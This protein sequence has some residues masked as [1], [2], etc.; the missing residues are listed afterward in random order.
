MRESQEDT[1]AFRT[2]F[3]LVELLVV[4]AIIGL[5]VALLLPAVQAAREAARRSQC[6]NNLRQLAIAAQN[7]HA[8]KG[9]FPS[10]LDQSFFTSAPSYRGSS[11]FVFLLPYLEEA[12]VLAAWDYNDPLNNTL[13][14]PNSITAAVMSVL[15]CPS[16]QIQTNPVVYQ[17]IYYGLTSY[18]GNGGSRSS[19]PTLATADGVFHTTGP[20]AEP[21][22]A[23]LPIRLRDITDGTSH[24]LFFGERSQSDP[25]YDAFAA[26]GWAQYPFASTGWWAPVDRRGIGHVTMSAYSPINFRMAYGPANGASNVPPVVNDGTFQYYVDYRICS[27]GSEHPGGANFAL[28]DGSVRFIGDDL[29]QQLLE[30]LSTRAGGEIFDP[31]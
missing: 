29:S 18:G 10:G 17:G 4:I 1:R 26:M 11:L 25:N 5:L 7:H 24:V 19:F 28:V 21:S 15:I 16:D 2:G 22:T 12:N 13:A 8:A 31:F 9:R 27:W 6:Q 3:T 23:Q 20:A 14:G 30:S